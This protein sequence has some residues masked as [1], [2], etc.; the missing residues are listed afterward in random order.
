MSR[1]RLVGICGNAGVGK[2][3]AA[4][5]LVDKH[6][7]T[8]IALAD[9]IKRF[10]QRIFKFS[11]KQLWGPSSLRDK[12]DSRY[13]TYQDGCID[14]AWTKATNRLRRHGRAWIRE[15]VNPTSSAGEDAAYTALCRWFRWLGTTH[16]ELSPRVVLQSLGTEWGRQEVSEDLWV[17]YSLRVTSKLLG[18]DLGTYYTY[19]KKRG[20]VSSDTPVVCPGVVVSDIRFENELCMIKESGGF[21]IWILRDGA[22]NGVGLLDHSSEVTQRDFTRTQFNYTI[23]NSN[24]LEE[25]YTLI[26][27]CPFFWGSGE[28]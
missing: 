7:F 14:V 5:R 19:S 27:L 10:S 6:A 17:N 23:D 15:T 18:E 9:P 25:L 22:P 24:T 21:L 8:Q 12:L 3:T 1:A 11:D 16:P 13:R 28:C 26:D 4:Q 2:D 20:L